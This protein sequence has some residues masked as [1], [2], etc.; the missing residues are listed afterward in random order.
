VETI[1]AIRQTLGDAGFV[2]FCHGNALKYLARAGHK[3]AAAQ[4]L[5]KAGWYCQ[6]AA[7]V[8]DPARFNDPRSAAK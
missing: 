2:A 7:H 8:T 5:A 3:D 6:M 4:D 1:D